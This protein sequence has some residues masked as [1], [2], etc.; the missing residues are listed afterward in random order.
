[1]S[2][3]ERHAFQAEVRQLLDIV[4]HALYTDREIFLRELVSNASDALEKLRHTQLTGET[5]FDANLPLEI[6]ITTD[7]TAGTVTIQDFGIGMTQEELVENLG[8]I[9]HSG[10]KAFLQA[11]KEKGGAAENLIGQ[12]GVGFYSAFMVASEVKVYTHSWQTDAPGLV[13]T[14]DGG[15]D[16]AIEPVEGQRRGC[17]IVLKLKDDAKEFASA[18]RVRQ[19]L[20]RYSNY[21]AFPVNLNGERVNKV[22]AIWLKQ[23]SEVTPEQYK[24]FY[25]FQTHL[26]DEP[27][28]WLHFSVDAPLALNALLFVPGVNPERMGFGRTPPGVALYCRKVLIDPEPKELLPEWLRFLRGVV[29]SA[30]LPLNISR[31]SM[32]DSALVQKLNRV[33]TKRFLKFLE[34]LSNKDAA[35][36]EKIYR[37]FQ[38]YIKEG[39]ATDY[40]HRTALSGLLRFESSTQP[41]GQLTSL[42]DYVARM[43]S[44]QKEIYFL[45]G[46]DRAAVESGP[47]LEAFK[48]RGLEV[49]LGFEP[50]DDFVMSQLGAFQEKPI[51]NAD[52]ADLKLPE[53]P[54]APGAEALSSENLAALCAWLKEILGENRVASVEGGS[55]LVDSP[56]VALNSDSMVSANM[57]RI[58]RSMKNEEQAPP[59]AVVLQINPRHPL[60][61]NLAALRAKDADLAKLVGE[62]LYDSALL[63]GGLLEDPR[64]FVQRSYTLLERVS[65]N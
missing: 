10:S 21:V 17:K 54:D 39:I 52:Q 6:N 40:E 58:L 61:K 57:R 23:K 19:L 12:F 45:H 5:P 42:A 4:V 9:A 43:T 16:Y 25:R 62:Q 33:L 46:R 22:E 30:D 47:Y 3:P 65:K 29:D 31:E 24:E 50:L 59:P 36:Y 2:Q 20:A 48:A 8:T 35:A 18:D 32:Q 44:E 1:M 11:L 34:E 60:V 37:L 64:Q 15:G 56:A 49:L 13:W 27:L 41:A 38:H 51:V 14:S 7:D 26:P 53:L 63:A 55:R 28:T